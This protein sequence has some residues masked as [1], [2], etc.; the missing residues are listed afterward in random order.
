MTLFLGIDAGGT[1]SKSRL[2]D[3][4]GNILG[5]GHAG[6]ANTRIGLDAL[7]AT[8]LDVSMQAIRA[9]GLSAE[10]AGKIRCGMGIAGITR[11]GMKQ[12]IQGLTFPFANVQLTSDAMIANLGAHM[13]DDGAILIIGTGS[14][15]LVKRGE[16]SFSIGG[17]GF[18]ISD[19]GSGAA[20]GLSAI[21]H[22]LRALDG[23]TRPSPLSQAVTKQF[24]HAIPRVIAW[25]DDAAPGD[26]AS[27]APLVMDYADLGDEIALSIVRDA[28]LHVERFIET[29]L[30]RGAPRCVLMGGLAERMKPWLRVRIVA[31]LQDALGDALDGALILA[32]RPIGSGAS[33]L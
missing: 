31:Q 12:K 1:S 3:E 23:R 25:M 16:D 15:G 26:Y 32:G 13:G 18:P 6:P 10:D 9:A 8:L 11:M 5:S 30:S 33:R 14:V 4:D 20:L 7:H 19:E 17:Y 2:T 27:F 22:A 28:A 21:R 29:I 24:D